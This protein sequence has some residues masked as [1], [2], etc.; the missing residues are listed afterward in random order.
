MSSFLNTKDAVGFTR[1]GSKYRSSVVSVNK[2]ETFYENL[3]VTGSSSSSQQSDINNLS[4]NTKYFSYVDSTGS[5]S[6]LGIISLSSVGKN[7]I[8][9]LSLTYNQP[10]IRAH[11]ATITDFSFHRFDQQKIFSCSLD[12]TIKLWQVPDEGLVSDLTTPLMTMQLTDKALVKGLSLHTCSKEILAGRGVRTIDVYD[13]ETEKSFCTIPTSSSVH[14][15]DIQSMEWSNM[16]DI[17]M[18][19]CKDQQLRFFDIRTNGA[20]PSATTL[21]HTGP[22]FS[23]VISLGQSTYLLTCGHTKATQ[24]REIML[25]DYR[26]MSSGALHRIRIDSGYG[27]LIPLFDC[28]HN[29]LTMIGKGKN[30]VLVSISCL[31]TPMISCMLIR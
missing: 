23:R 21:A 3:K 17:L 29:L 12:Q 11:S 6:A 10:L 18:T 7:H 20:T 2:R 25:W 8:P 16:G 14:S 24:E 4:C 22:R 30:I 9:V 19:T 28:D 5:G 27:S 15:S 26:N 13:I 1:Y 31:F